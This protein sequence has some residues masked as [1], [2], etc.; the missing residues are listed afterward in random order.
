MFRETHLGLCGPDVEPKQKRYRAEKA[1]RFMWTHVE[2]KQK[3]YGAE[4]VVT[5]IHYVFLQ[6]NLILEDGRKQL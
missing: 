5:M 1:S 6:I 2:R 3:R 4:M